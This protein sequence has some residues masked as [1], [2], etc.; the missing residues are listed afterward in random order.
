MDEY[1]PNTDL[2][3]FNVLNPFELPAQSGN[4]LDNGIREIRNLSKLLGLDIELTLQNWQLLLASV[5]DSR[6]YLEYRT[7]NPIIF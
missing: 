2:E 3:D 5:I 7:G 6:D 4:V 1:F